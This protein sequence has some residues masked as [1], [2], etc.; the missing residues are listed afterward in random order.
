MARLYEYRIEG[1]KQLDDAPNFP[2]ATVVTALVSLAP[3]LQAKTG[4]EIVL[5]LRF[6]RDDSLPLST[7]RE[8]VAEEVPRILQEAADLSRAH[9]P[10]SGDNIQNND[11]FGS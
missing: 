7:L 3:P 10:R 6:P 2:G 11:G 1:I 8:M 4:Y 9:I 5:T